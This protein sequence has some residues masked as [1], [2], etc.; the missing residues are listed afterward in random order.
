[1]GPLQTILLKYVQITK[2]RMQSDQYFPRKISMND[3]TETALNLQFQV[4]IF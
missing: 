3:A 4:K 1:M 2:G